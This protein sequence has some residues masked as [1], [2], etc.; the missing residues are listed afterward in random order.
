MAKGS[1]FDIVSKTDMNEVRNAVNQ[2][3][4]EVQQR[5]DFKGSCSDIRIEDE[6]LVLISDDEY[7]LQSLTAI[8]EEKLIRRKVSLKALAYGKVES[9]SGGSVRQIVDIQQ[10]IPTEKAKE[11][12]KLIKKEKLKVQ[13]A[14]QG[15]TVRVSGKDKD[16]LQGVIQ[17][18][19][20][21]DMGIDIQFTNYR[22]N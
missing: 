6:K 15:D 14:I 13:A 20:A 10:G 8:L 21:Q 16:T 5:F 11:I 4:K 2:S 9:A 12:V 7:K 1:S 18:I 22:S 17:L 3:M 19:K